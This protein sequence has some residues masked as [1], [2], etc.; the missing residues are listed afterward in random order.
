MEGS[1]KPRAAMEECRAVEGEA[2]N[3]GR[4]EVRC[5]FLAA[6]AAAMSYVATYF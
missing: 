4:S 5:V 3:A 2:R 1:G 6:F